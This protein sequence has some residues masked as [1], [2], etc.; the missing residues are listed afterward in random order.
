MP[1]VPSAGTSPASAYELQD[2]EPQL[3]P[4]AILADL[5]DP[6]TGE[7]DSVLRSANLA[8]AMVIEAVRIERGSGAAV[9]D[10]GNRFAE[11][12]HVD[13]SGPEVVESMARQAL[14]PAREA[15]VVELVRVKVT[16]N[17]EDPSEL[18]TVLEYRD[19]LA[20]RDAENRSFTLKK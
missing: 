18:D 19:L 15:G 20:A 3:P 7:Y 13:G 4:P 1:S 2:Y 5:I 8:D 16:P 14:E 12:T 9:R 11:I 6:L 17:A 10:L